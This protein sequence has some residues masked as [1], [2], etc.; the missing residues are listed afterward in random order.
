MKSEITLK[1]LRKLSKHLHYYNSMAPFPPYDT[2]YVKDVDNKIK[3]I[4]E[5]NK[6]DYDEESVVAC[7]YC[8]SLHIETDELNNDVCMKCGSI[9]ELQSFKNIYE[10]KD[11]LK[12]GKDT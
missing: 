3:Q 6:K 7:K 4:M 12:N 5:N 2:D 11:F 9:N 8:K 10:Y 1:E